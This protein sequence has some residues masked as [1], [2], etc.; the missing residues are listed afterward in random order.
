[1][2]Y[3]TRA[4]LISV[5]SSIISS[6]RAGS[7]VVF[8]FGPPTIPVAS[9]PR[10]G[11]SGAYGSPIRLSPFLSAATVAGIGVPKDRQLEIQQSRFRPTYFDIESFISDLKRIGF[12]DVRHFGSKEMNERYSKDRTDGLR[13]GNESGFRMHP[14]KA[15]L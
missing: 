3:L 4:A 9:V 10:S 12:S 13:I 11:S 2:R 8:D 5:L 15:R 6:L 14:V 7:E 1:M